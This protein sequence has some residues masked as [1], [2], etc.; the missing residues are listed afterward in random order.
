MAKPCC[1]SRP[2]AD[3]GN[4]NQSFFALDLSWVLGEFLL[5]LCSLAVMPVVLL[6]SIWQAGFIPLWH[7]PTLLCC[8]KGGVCLGV[9]IAQGPKNSHDSVIDTSARRRDAGFT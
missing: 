7:S 2:G 5:G 1:C 6:D 9:V 4:L 3:G 8:M